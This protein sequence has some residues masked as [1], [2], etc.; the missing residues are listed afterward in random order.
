MKF[1]H[2]DHTNLTQAEPPEFFPKYGFVNYKTTAGNAARQFYFNTGSGY[3]DV[4]FVLKPYV[5]KRTTYTMN[6]SLNIAKNPRTNHYL[7]PFSDLTDLLNFQHRGNSATW[8]YHRAYIEF[9]T[10]GFLSLHQVREVWIPSNFPLEKFKVVDEIADQYALKVYEMTDARGRLVNESFQANKKLLLDY[11]SKTI[12]SHS[13]SYLDLDELE[14]HYPVAPAWEK[15]HIE[16]AY[17]MTKDATVPISLQR[18][19]R[20]AR[21]IKNQGILRLEMEIPE[22]FLSASK[23]A[24]IFVGLIYSESKERWLTQ[25]DADDFENYLRNHTQVITEIIKLTGAHSFLRAL[26]RIKTRNVNLRRYS[27][28]FRI[29]HS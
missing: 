4:I 12:L 29:S 5:G 18:Q 14:K 3:G 25:K 26:D 9:Q 7:T 2:V 19:V 20:A 27:T 13:K 17:S 6:D 15:K 24:E 16:S 28:L 10:W 22:T 21:K 8:P 23:H 1:L 11:S